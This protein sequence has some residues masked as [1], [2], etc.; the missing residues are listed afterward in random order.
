[1]KIP[2]CWEI[3]AIDKSISNI[4]LVGEENVSRFLHMPQLII[5]LIQKQSNFNR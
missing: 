1:M 3:D 5:L 4:A 2:P